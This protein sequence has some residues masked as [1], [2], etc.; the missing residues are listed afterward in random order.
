M[1]TTPT[2]TTLSADQTGWPY[3]VLVEV[4]A[5]IGADV[6]E[7]RLIKFTINAAFALPGSGLVVR[8]AGSPQV[9]RSAPKVVKVARWLADHQM[10]SVR[11]ATDLPQP[12]EVD[13]HAATV[14]KLVPDT[15]VQVNGHD[16]GRILRQF[17]ALPYT[18][19]GL[20]AWNPLGYVHARVDAAEGLTRDERAFLSETADAVA[21]D[22]DGVDYF[23]EPG[24]IHG[25]AFVGNL[26]PGPEGAIL[27][28]FDSTCTGPR[29]WDLIPVAVG[30]LRF[31]H[32]VDYHAQLAESYGVDILTWPGFPVLR[33]LR[34][35][36][37]VCS[38]LPR[39]ASSRGVR[40]QWRRRFDT[41]RAGDL[42]A[43]WTPYR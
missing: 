29:E 39:I 30:Q 32:A 37:S 18:P 20:P 40:E 43:R 19:I 22:L 10:P 27:C 3:R 23:L 9:A 1:A 25:D 26:I 7:A 42:D 38:V 28:D 17:H 31:R 5:R 2:A 33:R 35:L 11:L 24:P 36:R 16:L 6:T 41:L 8:I 12:L 4:C 14:W 21:S 13:G 15:G 34:E